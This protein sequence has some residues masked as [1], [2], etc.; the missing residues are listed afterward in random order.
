[1]PDRREELRKA[2][3]KLARTWTVPEADEI[4]RQDLD[5]REFEE[6]ER[7]KRE[8]RDWAADA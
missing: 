3:E 1:M 5:R 4:H 7:R 8:A 2:M 6:I